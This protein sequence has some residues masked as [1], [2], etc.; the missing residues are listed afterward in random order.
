MQKQRIGRVS[1]LLASLLMAGIAHAAAAEVTADKPP[2]AS[3]SPSKHLEVF[4]S[5]Q[6]LDA[7][8]AIWKRKYEGEHAQRQKKT[9]VMAVGAAPPVPVTT[10]A[11]APAALDSVAVTGS[12]VA[13][14]DAITNVQTVGVD[15]GGIVKRHGDYL[16]VLR[17]GRLFSLRIGGDALQ[18]V[19]S[20]DAYAPGLKGQ[21]WYD[22]MLISGNRVVVIGYSYARK[23]TEVGLFEIAK[24]GQ[25]RY[26]DTWHL[27]SGDY[28]S[29]RNYASRL[30]GSTLVFYAPLRL[31]FWG[32][33]MLEY[34][35][36][37][38]WRG[39]TVPQ[40]FK[41]L[42]PAEHIYRADAG[43]DPLRDSITL[44]TVT[45][46]EL[47]TLPITCTAT[48]VLGPT[49]REF[50]VSRNA[51]YVWTQRRS[52]RANEPSIASV[53]RLPLDGGGVSALRTR[54]APIDQFSFLEDA[55]Y[56]NVLVQSDGRGGGMW[57]AEAAAGRLALLRAPL[58]DFGGMSHAAPVSAYRLLPEVPNG[59]R[60]NRYIGH[61]LVYAGSDWSW[62]KR[63]TTVPQA[64]ALGFADAAAP[65]LSL[66]PTHDVARIE[67]LGA[68]AVLVGN[69]G[70]NLLFSS[71]A[72]T[73]NVLG[74]R[75]S[76]AMAD[77]EQGE[78]RSHGFF[79]RNDGVQEGVIG[80]PVTRRGE[81]PARGFLGTPDGNAVVT[82]LRNHRLRWTP[83]GELVSRVEARDDHCKASCVDWYGNA[84]PIFIGQRAFAL[85]GYELVEGQIS[86]DR[87]VER[88][89]I[90]FTPRAASDGR[91][92]Q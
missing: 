32:S 27:R 92:D 87:I 20:V 40:E 18:A 3:S 28:Y 45:H 13:A 79:Y 80:L 36:V 70:Q 33:D 60:Q 14:E 29:S 90:D 37:S 52:N 39:D 12:T 91:A 57:G 68:D 19:S 82:Y 66:S 89:R 48:G 83:L 11:S 73:G 17:R 49:G 35:G 88:R 86:A 76:Y 34:P 63:A 9:S 75:D 61:W 59:N 6:A 15:E 81:N 47:A 25:L 22:E 23:G 71:V 26:L 31:S 74:I 10:T 1:A 24:D 67:A 55:G 53:L 56:L 16:V 21:A 41:R 54:G 84:R 2:A 77:A 58:S 4:R 51:V 5:Q 69:Q 50:Y 8:L 85:M 65:I 43:L 38:H 78:R 64:Y 46:C 62:N 30:I 42:L 7:Q 72:L 44:H